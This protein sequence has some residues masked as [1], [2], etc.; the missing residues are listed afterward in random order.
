MKPIYLDH[1]AT[2]PITEEVAEA[3]VPFLK[4]YFGNPSSS[5]YYGI[6]TK[7]AITA[8]RRQVADLLG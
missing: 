3:M 7:K 1:N 4:E 2:T 5:H 8:A 6:Q